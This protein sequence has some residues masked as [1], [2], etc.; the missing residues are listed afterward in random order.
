MALLS[1][2]VGDPL[3]GQYL[4]ALAAFQEVEE[5]SREDSNLFSSLEGS[6]GVVLAQLFSN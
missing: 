2:L 5:L 1:A 3:T 4:L 6:L